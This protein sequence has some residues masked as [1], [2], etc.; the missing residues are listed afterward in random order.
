VGSIGVVGG[1]FGFAKLMDKI[2]IE[3]RLYTS[4]ENKAML[5]PFLPEKPEDVEKLKAVQK[6][7]HEGFIDLVKQSR[8]AQ[9]IQFGFAHTQFLSDAQ[10]IYSYTLKV[11]VRRLVFCLDREG[12]RLDGPEVYSRG[13]FSVLSGVNRVV[14][15]GVGMVCRLLVISGV[16]MFGCFPVVAGGMRKMF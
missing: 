8:G 16:V 12:Q 13:F 15:R 11:I 10:R 3:R 9:C 4:G 14:P 2:G 7:I 5:D 6:D 1:S